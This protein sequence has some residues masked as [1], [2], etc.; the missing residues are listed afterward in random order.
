MTRRGWKRAGIKRLLVGL[1]L[2]VLAWIV[3]GGLTR[4]WSNRGPVQQVKASADEIARG[5]YLADAADCA[6]CHTAPGGA[7][8]AGGVPLAS[9]FGAIHGT[10]ITPDPDNGIG[11]YTA[12][13]FFHALTEGEARDGHQ[14][15]PA[16]PY[17]SYKTLARADSD[18]IYAYLMHQPPVAQANAKND[19]R[20]PGQ[21]PHRAA[22][23][24]PVVRRRRRTLRFNR[25]DARVA[26]RSLSGRNARPLRRVPQPAR[27]VGS[28]RSRPPAGRQ[29]RA[30]PLRRPRPHSAGPGRARLGCGDPAAVPGY[31][32]Q[33][34]RGRLR[35]NAPRGGVCRPAGSTRAIWAR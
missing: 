25:G 20:F 3:I 27:C 31:R 29:Q 2:I 35:R 14:L 24:E 19:V 8:F 32:H 21:H 22:R 1:A 33:R 7:P 30:G 23:V 18:A 34:P 16:M 15:Y 5:R 26:A 6:A 4:W 13:D 12:D 11:R 28:G 10:N 9:P 17:V